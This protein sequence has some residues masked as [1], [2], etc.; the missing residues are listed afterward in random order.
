[1]FINFDYVNGKETT[2]M[3]EFHKHVK[4][5]VVFIFSIL[6]SDSSAI[7]VYIT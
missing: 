7:E 5:A 2:V 6:D 4:D 3:T 1:M